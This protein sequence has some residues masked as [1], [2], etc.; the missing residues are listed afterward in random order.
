MVTAGELLHCPNLTPICAMMTTPIKED[1][2][3]G[4]SDNMPS[5]ESKHKVSAQCLSVSFAFCRKEEFQRRPN[6]EE[7]FRAREFLEEQELGLRK[8]STSDQGSAG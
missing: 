8:G 3:E 5:P 2:W 1:C 7:N 6:P 4:K